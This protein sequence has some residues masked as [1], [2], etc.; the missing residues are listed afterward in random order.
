MIKSHIFIRRWSRET[1]GGVE[2][3]DSGALEGNSV[4]SNNVE[5]NPQ[6]Q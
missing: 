4:M 3:D 5:P 6:C 1:V 2:K